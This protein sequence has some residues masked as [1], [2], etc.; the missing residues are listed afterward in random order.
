MPKPKTTS[1][2]AT[3]ALIPPARDLCCDT[4]PK[5]EGVKVLV[6]AVEVVFGF[7]IQLHV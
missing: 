7:G 6:A 2:A 5:Q 3:N 4:N 1:T